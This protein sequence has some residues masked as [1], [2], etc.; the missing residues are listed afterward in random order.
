MVSEINDNECSA[1][2]GNYTGG[3]ASGIHI[4]GLRGNL[5]KNEC[6]IKY[7]IGAL[8]LAYAVYVSK[9]MRDNISDA[10]NEKYDNI[11]LAD[12]PDIYAIIRCIIIIR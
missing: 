2:V 3:S 7:N 6:K 12:G 11:E 8:Q 4:D 1:R 5:K 10:N 9:Y